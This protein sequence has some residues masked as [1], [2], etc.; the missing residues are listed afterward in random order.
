MKP[1]ESSNLSHEPLIRINEWIE[2]AVKLA[3][4]VLT[5]DPST[6]WWNT[7]LFEDIG[8]KDHHLGCGAK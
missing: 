3:I 5:F 2:E 6:S 1:F 7:N 8:W 4:G